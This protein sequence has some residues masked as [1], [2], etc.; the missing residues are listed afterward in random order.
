M[1][2][3]FDAQNNFGEWIQN[4]WESDDYIENSR[5]KPRVRKSAANSAEEKP[6][7][8]HYVVATI[9]TL[10]TSPIFWIAIVALAFWIER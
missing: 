2:N 4:D 9:I 5:R 8:W 3:A 6:K 7:A 10:A 1:K